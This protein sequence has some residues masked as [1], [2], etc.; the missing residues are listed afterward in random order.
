MIMQIVADDSVFHRVN[1]LLDLR[2]ICLK[3]VQFAGSPQI[4]DEFVVAIPNSTDWL[5]GSKAI[6]IDL[7]AVP[8]R[9]DP[10]YAGEKGDRIERP[11][12]SFTRFWTY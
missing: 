2:E 4:Q 11:A 12:S 3:V 6:V 10:A 1:H 9:A 8:L 5:K 7:V